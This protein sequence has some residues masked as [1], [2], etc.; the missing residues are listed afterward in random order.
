MNPS[1]VALVTLGSSQEMLFEGGPRPWVLEPSK[2]FRNVTSEDTHSISLALLGPP[3]SRNY[4]QHWIL[5]TCQALGEQVRGQPHPDHLA[6]REDPAVF[7][8][9]FYLIKMA[10]IKLFSQFY[11]Q[12]C[13]YI[14]LTYRAEDSVAIPER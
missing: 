10:V 9:S 4:Q 6:Q 5:V 7:T 13:C 3:A 11:T 1:S 8:A 2:F 14:H 12:L